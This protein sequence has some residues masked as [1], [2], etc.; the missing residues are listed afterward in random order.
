MAA[1]DL[2]PTGQCWCGCGAKTSL[3]AFFLPGH[4]KRAEAAVVKTR[5]RTIPDFL[6]A[7]DFGPNGKNPSEELARFQAQG[8]EYL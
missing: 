4:D 8:G 3:G 6:V 7:H 2:I 1:T 5:Y